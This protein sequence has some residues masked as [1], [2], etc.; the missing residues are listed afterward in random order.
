MSLIVKAPLNDTSIGNVSV[1]IL[2]ELYKLGLNIS[3]FPI[4]NSISLEAF[5][6]LDKD[7]V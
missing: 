1:N 6:E 7:F 5:D 4:Q 2:R 3:L